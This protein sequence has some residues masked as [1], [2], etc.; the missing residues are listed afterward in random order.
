MIQLRRLITPARGLALLLVSHALLAAGLLLWLGSGREVDLPSDG[1]LEVRLLPT[2]A[3][4]IWVHLVPEVGYSTVHSTVY[5]APR[6]LERSLWMGAWYHNSGR[7]TTTRLGAMQLP[8]WALAVP[9]GG[10][11][12]GALGLAVGR[13]QQEGAPETGWTMASAGRSRTG[14]P[15]DGPRSRP[16][17]HGAVTACLPVVQGRTGR[18]KMSRSACC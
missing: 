8:L 9:M 10:V 11:A 14:G 2:Q 4:Q 1:R 5:H 15:T 3:L 16:R 17:P 7:S 12:S 18:E 13:R 6:A